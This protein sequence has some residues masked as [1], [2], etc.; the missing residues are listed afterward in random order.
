VPGGGHLDYAEALITA[1]ETNRSGT[2]RVTTDQC[3]IGHRISCLD[4]R[5]R[6][7]FPAWCLS[8]PRWVQFNGW[9]I[10]MDRQ[11]D[12]RYFSG[13]HVFPVIGDDTAVER[14]P[15]RIRRP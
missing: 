6:L 2:A 15:R 10:R 12:P 7:S 11:R 4:N 13:D 9:V 5:V 3:R 14:F 8:S 1:T